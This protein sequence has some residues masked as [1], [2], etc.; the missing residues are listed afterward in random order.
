MMMELKKVAEDTIV[1]LEMNGI[2]LTLA[3]DSLR[4]KRIGLWLGTIT[5]VGTLVPL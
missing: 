3:M 2:E 5:K 1:D 4:K